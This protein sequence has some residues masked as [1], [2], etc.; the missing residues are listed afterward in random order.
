MRFSCI[1]PWLGLC[2]KATAES[3]SFCYISMIF[4]GRARHL[5]ISRGAAAGSPDWWSLGSKAHTRSLNMRLWTVSN[6]Y[7]R[8]A[9]ANQT[10]FSES[11]TVRLQQHTFKAELHAAEV[12]IWLN[13][14]ILMPCAKKE[15]QNST[16]T[17]YGKESY[18]PWHDMSLHLYSTT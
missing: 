2:W 15:K 6:I 18:G 17:C 13:I 14:Y 10:S 9:M 16:D 3:R 1:V 7:N 12:W 8:Q 4:P 5:W 11:A